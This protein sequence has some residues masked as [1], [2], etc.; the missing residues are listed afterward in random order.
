MNRTLATSSSRRLAG[1]ATLGAALTLMPIAAAVAQSLPPGLAA[2][3][4]ADLTSVV[5]QALTTNPEVHAAW[6]GLRAADNDVDV[7]FGNYLPSV[8]ANAGIGREYR[9]GEPQFGDRSGSYETRFAEITLTQMIYDGFATA[10]EVERLDRAKLVRYYELIGASENVTLEATRAYLDVRRYR[11]LVSLAQENYADHLRVF[12][13]IEERVQSGAGR[14]VDLEQ[15]SGRLALAESNLMTEASNLHDVTARFQ[16]IVGELPAAQLAP[17][18]ELD[19]RLPPNVAAALDMAFQGNPEFHAAIENIEASRAER[20]GTK[21][22]FHPRLDLRGR[23]GTYRND[24]GYEGLGDRERQT[25]ELVAS[26]NLY[27]GGSDLASFRAASDR[28]EQSINLREKA[29]VDVRQ[30]TQIAYNDTQRLREQLQYLNQHRLSIDRVRGAYQQQFDIGQRTLLDVLDSENEYFEASRAFVNAQ[31]DVALADAR[32]LA[33]MGQ[34]MKTLGVVR[35][36]MPTLAEM[37]S[38]GVALDPETICPADGPMGFTLADFTGGIE[39]PTRAPDITLSADALFQINSAELSAEARGELADLA[40]QIRGRTDLARVFIA[41]HA[42]TTGN[43]AI[44]DP[45]SQRRADSVASYLASQGVD[46]DLLQTRGY[47]SHQ[48]VATNATVEGRRQNRRVEV[49]L[50]R[51]GEN[52]DMTDFRPAALDSLAS[53]SAAGE[54]APMAADFAPVAGGLYAEIDA[55]VAAEPASYAQLS[56]EVASRG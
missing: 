50:E 23:A 19:D 18:P 53:R 1:A 41:G 8:D 2:P 12:S 55:L 26:M 54:P 52:L 24:S 13:Q 56:P 25:I 14:G 32:T 11:E 17:A 7:A 6:N 34:L 29:C 39:A 9:E 44:N 42:D 3:G 5:R 20:E 48:P 47:G 38:D 45:L 10:S 43:D 51:V 46:R 31:Y 15:I 40:E 28:V 37:G 22:A 16:R 36:D 27:R 49:T 35:D 30:T 33:A 4:S 21:A